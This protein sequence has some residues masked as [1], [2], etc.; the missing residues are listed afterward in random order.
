MAL[1]ARSRRRIG[2]D[3]Q[4]EMSEIGQI[5]QRVW[6]RKEGEERSGRNSAESD[7]TTSRESP[8]RYQFKRIG[9]NTS[10][11]G[12]L[13]KGRRDLSVACATFVFEPPLAPRR[14]PPAGNAHRSSAP[15]A[16]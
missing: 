1:S 11:V 9:D 8:Y 3:L 16:A 10:G 14:I 4:F 13:E 2:M 15:D 6:H 12:P 7:L 5:G